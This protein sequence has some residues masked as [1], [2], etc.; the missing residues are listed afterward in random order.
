MGFS[1]IITVG[2]HHAVTQSR[3]K[4]RTELAARSSDGVLKFSNPADEGRGPAFAFAYA[5]A[6]R[7]AEA[8]SLAALLALLAVGKAERSVKSPQRDFEARETAIIRFS[9]HLSKNTT[10]SFPDMI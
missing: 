6:M 9:Y 2:R 3:H 1:D 4:I 5:P 10:A 7:E 8:I